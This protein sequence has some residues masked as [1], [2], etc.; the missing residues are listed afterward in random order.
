MVAATV[1]FLVVLLAPVRGWDRHIS[2]TAAWMNLMVFSNTG[3][4][5]ANQPQRAF[6][7]GNQSLMSVVHR[8]TRPVDA[9][10]DRDDE[11]LKVNLVDIRPRG[12]FM[13]FGLIAGE[14]CLWYVL[15]MPPWA[16]RTRASN[17]VGYAILP[18]MIP[19]S[20]PKAATYYFCW[21]I[22]GP[23][24]VMAEVLRAG[25]GGPR[26]GAAG[27]RGVGGCWAG[28]CCRSR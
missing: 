28:W 20:S 12:P 27:G 4:G 24:L 16:G 26:S 1:V 10:V 22:P 5:L 19:L 15:A 8:L 2:E 18:L 3:E 21:A 13:V 11:T 9:G 14:L 17:G 6:R 25:R 23:V 7:F